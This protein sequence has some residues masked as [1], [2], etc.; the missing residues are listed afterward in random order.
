MDGIIVKVKKLNEDVVMP[1]KATEFSSGFDLYANIKEKIII[2]PLERKLINSGMV[3]EI[4]NGYEGQ[5]RPRSSLALKN[6]VTVLNSPGTIDCDYRGEVKILLINLSPDEFVIQS[7][8]RIAQ[9]VF[10]KV[11]DVKILE[12]DSFQ[13]TVRGDGGFGSTGK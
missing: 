8:D 6:G 4:P 10:T 12:M 1:L 2:K 7:G 5:I 3:M 9:I 11:S 13:D